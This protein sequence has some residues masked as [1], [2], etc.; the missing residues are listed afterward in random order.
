MPSRS[1][2]EANQG[3]LF[4]KSCTIFPEEPQHG[5]VRG[6]SIQPNKTNSKL[7]CCSDICCL[8]HSFIPLYLSVPLSFT[9]RRVLAQTPTNTHTHTETHT[10]THTNPTH[11]ITTTN[12]N[13][14]MCEINLPGSC[15]RLYRDHCE[16]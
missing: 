5:H 13:E 14:G 9:Y 11:T 8:C 16:V 7:T 2:C 10:L 1:I 12:S 15:Q 6:H 3:R 4:S